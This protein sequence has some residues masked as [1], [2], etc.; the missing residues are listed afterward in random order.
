MDDSDFSMGEISEQIRELK[1][2]FR[3]MKQK[4][5]P[6]IEAYDSVIFG[7]KFLYGLATVIGSIVAIGGAV[8]WVIDYVRH[9]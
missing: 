7:R 1:G 6:I 4:L 3:A 5:D 2:E 8:I 9:G